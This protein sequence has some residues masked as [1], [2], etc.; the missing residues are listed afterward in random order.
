MEKSKSSKNGLNASAPGGQVLDDMAAYIRRYLVCDD[1]QLAILALWSASAYC[2]NHFFTAPYLHIASAQPCA[3]KSLCLA[4]L[5]DLSGADVPFTGVPA[6][7]ILERL[8]RDRSLDEVESSASLPPCLVLIDDYHH[9]FGLSE[10]QPLVCLLA[11]G[12]ESVGLFARGD[13]DYSLFGPKAFAGNSPLPRSLATR[14]I[15]INLRPLRPSEKFIRYGLDDESETLKTL[16]D[17]LRRW[18]QQASSALAQAAHNYPPSLPPTLSPG[19]LKYAE[20]LIHIADVAGGSWPARIRS[21]L[22]AVFDLAEAAPELQML[23]D[24]HAIFRDQNNPDFL[25][26]SDLLSGL[27]ALDH[28]PWSAWSSN[29][30]RRLADHLRPFGILSCRRHPSSDI[31]LMGYLFRDFHDAWERYLPQLGA[32]DESRISA[33]IEQSEPGIPLPPSG[34]ATHAERGIRAL[35]AD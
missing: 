10:R 1:H 15:P 30:G 8:I 13:E 9:S 7:P 2:H 4:L 5:C 21:A 6:A 12:S 33:H 29:S 27:R 14:C 23:F 28:R 22:T 16:K 11:S 25:S 18:L 20:P 19:Q 24:V 17:R 3:G 34:T 31:D 32:G 26:T 35:G